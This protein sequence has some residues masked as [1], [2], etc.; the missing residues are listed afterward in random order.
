MFNLFNRTPKEPAKLAFSTD[1]HC[2]IIPGI[3]DGA[4]DA[5]TGADLVDRLRGWGI[6]RIIASPHVTQHT[7]ENNIDTITAALE[8]L[9]AELRLRG[10]DDSIEHSAENR[11]DELMYRNLEDGTLIKM[12]N[13]YVLIEN[14]FMQEP[15]NLENLIF[16]LQIKGY[17]PILAHPERYDYY[18]NKHERLETLHN[19]GLLMQINLLSLAGAYGKAERKMAEW[20]MDKDLVDFVGTDLH[21]EPHARAIDKYLLTKEAHRDMDRLRGRLLNDTAFLPQ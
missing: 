15:W 13:D 8:E 2:H 21:M 1:I 9:K 19:A 16:D 6:T 7:F 10:R 3:D 5:A 18:H 12:P 17:R 20:L 14:S 4:P 11:I